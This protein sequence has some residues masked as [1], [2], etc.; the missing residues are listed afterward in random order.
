MA[1]I[2]KIPEKTVSTRLFHAKAKLKNYLKE[3]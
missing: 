2:L 1:S 3:E